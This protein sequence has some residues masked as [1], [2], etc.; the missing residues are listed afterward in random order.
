MPTVRGSYATL[1]P[2]PKIPTDGRLTFL[3]LAL[4]EGRILTNVKIE[5]DSLT[6]FSL[7]NNSKIKALKR[8]VTSYLSR[9][10]F[11]DSGVASSFP[12]A[13]FN[14]TESS[15]PDSYCAENN[16]TLNSQLTLEDN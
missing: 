9:S 11:E 7:R 6:G 14:L 13:S 8:R 3:M 10:A 5:E 1:T 16:G 2:D 12:G 15:N 4:K